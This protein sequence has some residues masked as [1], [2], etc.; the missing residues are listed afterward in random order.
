M[1]GRLRGRAEFAGDGA[2]IVDVGGVG[3]HV[4]ASANTLR[5]IAPGAEVNLLI[6][7]HVRED[8]IHL[9]GFTGEEERVWFKQLLTV[10][11]VGTKVAMAVLSA[12]QPGRLAAAIA[13]QDKAAFKGAPG[14]GPKLAERI[15]TELKSKVSTLAAVPAGAGKAVPG[16]GADV[17]DAISA[18]VNLGYNRSEAY[19]AVQKVARESKQASVSDLIRLGLKELAS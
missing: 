7:T 14:V 8:H 19:G 12:L 16:E 3:Y 13:A 4:F 18:L 2:V 9:Y 11:G 10:S 6:E 17:G 15:I 1:I 5:N